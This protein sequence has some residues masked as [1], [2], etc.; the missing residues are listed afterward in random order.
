MPF[1]ISDDVSI[2]LRL[3]R[4]VL[5]AV[6]AL[7]ALGFTVAMFWRDVQIPSFFDDWFGS[8]SEPKLTLVTLCVDAA[9]F[10][11]VRAVQKSDA[12]FK[13]ERKNH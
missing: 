6:F 11:A 8:W 12:K 7:V 4:A 9:A 5:V 2:I 10:F 13:R 1:Q 3:I